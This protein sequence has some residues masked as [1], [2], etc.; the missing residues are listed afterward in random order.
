MLVLA[1]FHQD[2]NDPGHCTLGNKK[3]YNLVRARATVTSQTGTRLSGV[4]VS[5]RFMDQYWTNAV[6][7]GITNAQG[8]VQF[9]FKGPCGVGTEAFL[10]ENATK[11]TRVLD[12]TTGVLAGSALPQ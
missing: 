8:V 2:P 6:V 5:G 1:K 9:D 12:R 11:G 4:L 3:E 10:V 7:S